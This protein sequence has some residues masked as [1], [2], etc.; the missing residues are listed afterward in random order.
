MKNI[1]YKK[2]F[3]LSQLQIALLKQ[4]KRYYQML[5]KLGEQINQGLQGIL[6]GI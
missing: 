3:V 1:F 2:F 6:A 4:W 5:S